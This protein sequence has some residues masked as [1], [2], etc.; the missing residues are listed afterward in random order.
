MS[1][2]AIANFHIHIIHH[3]INH[4]FSHRA[5]LQPDHSFCINEVMTPLLH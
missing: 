4:R 1:S 2:I 5:R 3:F